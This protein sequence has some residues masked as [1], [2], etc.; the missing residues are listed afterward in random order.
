MVATAGEAPG[1]D[2]PYLGDGQN[3]MLSRLLQMR[4]L[5]PYAYRKAAAMHR[6]ISPEVLPPLLR[7]AYD[8]NNSTGIEERELLAVLGGNRA[9]WLLGL[10]G[11]SDTSAD[12]AEAWSTASHGERKS[13]LRSCRRDNP[14]AALEMLKGDWK[15]ESAAHR[16]ELLACL[17]VNLG[18][19]D[20]QFP[21][22]GKGNGAQSHV[23]N[24]RFPACH[25]LP[26]HTQRENQIWQALGVVV[27]QS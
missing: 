11:C 15:N 13:I 21:I 20:E 2:L 19:A 7:R 4:F 9:R 3:A 16:N 1:E 24:A 6:I 22:D 26:G 27:R 18:K 17:Q 8:R 23:P 12:G 14:V 5:L 10:M 25:A